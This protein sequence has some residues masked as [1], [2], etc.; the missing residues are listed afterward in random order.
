MN[1]KLLL[2]NA[3]LSTSHTC[4]PLYIYTWSSSTQVV[5]AA[6]RW[7]IQAGWEGIITIMK[8]ELP[9]ARDVH[10]ATPSS[11]TST[12]IA[13]P[14]LGTSVNLAAAIGPK[15][16]LSA[17]SPSIRKDLLQLRTSSFNSNSI[18][19]WMVSWN[20]KIAIAEHCVDERSPSVH[21]MYIV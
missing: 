3:Y 20:V 18:S 15:A 17:T 21:P 16:A 6:I 1:A 5:L 12:T 19:S 9:H 10:H 11:V 4:A 14:N 8:T 2:I 13:F 7:N